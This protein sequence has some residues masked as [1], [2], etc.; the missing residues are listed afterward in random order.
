[1]PAGLI[2]E[3]EGV[4]ESQYDAV[5]QKLGLD[6]KRGTGD[7]PAGLV[8]HTAGLD[9]GTLIVIEVW[10]TQEQQAHFMETRLGGALQEVGVP[11][12]SRIAWVDVV[13]NHQP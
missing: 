8:S 2:L 7:W 3:F 13:A 10:D 4:T 11:A 6:P 1:M 12:P 9:D 5:N